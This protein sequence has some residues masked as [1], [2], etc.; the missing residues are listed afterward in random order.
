VA[1]AEGTSAWQQKT[2]EKRAR[3]RSKKELE[4][5]RSAPRAAVQGQGAHGRFEELNSVDY[6]KRNETNE[7][8]IPGPSAW[9][10][11]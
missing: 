3:R 2:E 10:R 6:Q 7:I 8:F 1:G 11:K 4:W 5:V 9:A